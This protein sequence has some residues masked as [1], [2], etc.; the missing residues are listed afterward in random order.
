MKTYKLSIL[1][2]LLLF[3]SISAAK[4]S[5]IRDYKECR[6][7][8]KSA[9]GTYSIEISYK[10][11]L[12][13]DCSESSLPYE[14][15]CRESIDTSKVYL[16]NLLCIKPI[17][18][19]EVNILTEN[20]LKIVSLTS[21]GVDWGDRECSGIS[22]AIK[23]KDLL[24]SRK[25]TPVYNNRYAGNPKIKDTDCYHCGPKD[26]EGAP[27]QTDDIGGLAIPEYIHL[28]KIKRETLRDKLEIKRQERR[29]RKS[30]KLIDDLDLI[31]PERSFF[32]DAVSPGKIRSTS[33]AQETES[34]LKI[35]WDEERAGMSITRDTSLRTS[36]KER[37]RQRQMEKEAK[38]EIK[39]WEKYLLNRD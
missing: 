3:S 33:V 38:K 32:D 15:E 9:D 35:E 21:L 37:I 19:K 26:I 22:P 16:Q 14:L 17:N 27:M 34:D 20:N 29:L 30:G 18:T 13:E 8:T 2:G 31:Q 39:D 4:N 28:S 12:F 7:T 10:V 5:R 23:S 25:E 36:L 24:C 11:E 1:I 6:T